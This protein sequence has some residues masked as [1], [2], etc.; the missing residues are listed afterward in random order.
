MRD[1]GLFLFLISFVIAFFGAFGFA[2]I[3]GIVGLIILA[4]G[5][6]N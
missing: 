5:G 4:I 2:F 6:D 1:V 3:T